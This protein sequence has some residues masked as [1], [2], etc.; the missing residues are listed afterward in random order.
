MVAKG[1]RLPDKDVGRIQHGKGSL[2]RMKIQDGLE[3]GD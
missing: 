3:G 2:V 1:A